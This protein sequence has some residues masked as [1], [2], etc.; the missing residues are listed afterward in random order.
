MNKKIFEINI[1]YV[2]N[3]FDKTTK[4]IRDYSNN[5]FNHISIDKLINQ[6][7]NDNLNILIYLDIGIDPR[8]QILGSL[9]LSPIQC[10]AMGHPITS[11]LM[12][13]DYVLSSKLM[14]P[15]KAKYHYS[16]KLIKLPNLGYCY[17]KPLIKPIKYKKILKKNNNIIF[18]NLQ[19]LHKLL[20]EDDHIYIDIIKKKKECL[21]WIMQGKNNYITSIFIERIS[22]LFQKYDLDVDKYFVFHKRCNSNN[23][24]NLIKQSDIIL[25]SF[26][27]SGYNTSHEAIN[28][29]KPIVTLPGKFMRGR[30][31]YAILKM[32]DI[33][34]LIAHTKDE[35][36]NIAV[37]LATDLDFKNL[38]INKIKKNKKNYLLIKK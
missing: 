5:F 13:I 7:N 30:H 12:N 2:G 11:G 36:V 4:E 17:E 35:Y 18:F 10:L 28:F 9:R 1:Y 19:N 15:H 27:W 23:F 14:E 8:M 29:N 25:D 33:E 16:E 6:I 34:D 21:F 24:F 20:P 3:K 31:T 38:I 32:L 22:K 37:K 26:N